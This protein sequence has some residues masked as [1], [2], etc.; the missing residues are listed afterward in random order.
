M[1]A[2]EDASYGDRRAAVTDAC[3]N[4]WWLATSKEELS[5]EELLRRHGER[6]V[7]EKGAVEITEA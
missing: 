1:K 3:G 5:T 4:Q 7:G 6:V 2:P